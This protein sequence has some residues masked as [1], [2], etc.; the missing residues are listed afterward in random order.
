MNNKENFEKIY[1]ETLN[2]EF[3]KENLKKLPENEQKI[4]LEA[5]KYYTSVLTEKFIPSVSNILNKYDESMSVDKSKK[6][7]KDE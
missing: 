2:N 4:I 5:L 3:I 7:I 6:I 1:N